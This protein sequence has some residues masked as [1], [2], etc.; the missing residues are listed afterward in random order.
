MMSSNSSKTGGLDSTAFLQ[1]TPLI[2]GSIPST[3]ILNEFEADILNI[4]TLP[5]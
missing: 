1:F 2:M 4:V 5:D 3:G